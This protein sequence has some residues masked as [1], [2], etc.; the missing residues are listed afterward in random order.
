MTVSGSLPQQETFD[1]CGI[2]TSGSNSLTIPPPDTFIPP[3]WTP[4]SKLRSSYP[5]VVV[6]YYH[7]TSLSSLR[8]AISTIT[9]TLS[10]WRAALN[11]FGVK[12]AVLVVS[13]G[14]G[15]NTFP[16]RTAFPEFG[17]VYNYSVAY[18]SW[19]N[20]T[21]DV[22]R[23]FI[24]SCTPYGIRPG[25]CKETSRHMQQVPSR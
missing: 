7:P 16:S 10:R 12:R 2:G 11:S 21:G 23:M 1:W 14:C 19:L 6:V 15:F 4:I 9:Y 20:G 22:A 5:V 18:S 17:F 8:D 13:H 25:F 24:D 3:T